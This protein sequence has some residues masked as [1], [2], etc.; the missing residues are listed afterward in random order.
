MILKDFLAA[1]EAM[2]A[3]PP[4][5]RQRLVAL[6]PSLTDEERAETITTIEPEY[7]DIEAANKDLIQAFDD[8]IAAVDTFRK[9][10]LPKVYGAIEAEEHAQAESILDDNIQNA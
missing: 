7:A 10:D 3:L 8:G 2:V 4:Y 6:G 5:L 9:Q 1:I